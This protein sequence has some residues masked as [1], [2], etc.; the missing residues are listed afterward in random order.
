MRVLIVE[1]HADTAES[2]ALLLRLQGVEVRVAYDG[3]NAIQTAR[4]FAPRVVVLDLGLP[5]SIDGWEVARKLK[6]LDK[7]SFIMAVTG[8]AREEDRK[9]SGAAGIDLHLA[10]PV[11]P[12]FIIELL[13]RLRAAG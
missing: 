6:A 12:G 13:L 2:L 7:A 5:G 11:E 10:K 4:E 1:D 9:K 8:Y 3:P